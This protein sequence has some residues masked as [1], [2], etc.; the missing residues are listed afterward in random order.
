M[1]KCQV[2][3]A[4]ADIKIDTTAIISGGCTPITEVGAKTKEALTTFTST[5][6]PFLICSICIGK[7]IRQ[8]QDIFKKK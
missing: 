7:S 2:C 3:D 8:A 6:E 4:P 5:V 1:E